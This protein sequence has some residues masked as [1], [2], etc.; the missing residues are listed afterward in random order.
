MLILRPHEPRLL[1]PVPKSQWRSPSQ[2]E[3]KDQFGNPGVRTRFRVRARLD[4]G[5]VVWCGWF[6]DRDDFDA[7][8]WALATERLQYEPALWDLP[9]VAWSPDI[10]PWVHYDF[11][12]LTDLTTTGSVLTFPSPTDWNNSDN[13]VVTIGAGASGAFSSTN[14]N[15]T[16]SG[17]GGLSITFNITFATPGTTTASFRVGAGGASKSSGSVSGDPG[18]DTWFNGTTLALS[19]VGSKGGTGGTTS[20]VGSINGGA[21]GAAAS[22]IGSTKYSGGR[23]GNITTNGNCA[24]GGGS[25]AADNANGNNGGD[26]GTTNTDTAGGADPSGLGGAGGA[27]KYTGLGV[28]GVSGSNYG[29]GGGAK[30]GTN[31]SG[32]GAQGIIRVTWTPLLN[33][34]GNFLM[35]F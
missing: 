9:S 5:H 30:T 10:G 14:I 2:A 18:G 34:A 6:D 4:D 29:G 15:A 35:F 8:L 3:W 12:G 31:A 22:G 26:T 19:S 21:G 33:S 20:G 7:F 17:G 11:A 13:N 25:A 16:G 27:G 23:G 24:T 32:A 1:L 28:N